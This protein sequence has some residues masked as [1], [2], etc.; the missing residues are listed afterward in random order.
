VTGFGE[1]ARQKILI[2]QVFDRSVKV[3][4]RC[5]FEK[6]KFYLRKVFGKRRGIKQI[7]KGIQDRETQKI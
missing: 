3:W 6:V 2:H 5:L 4:T 7:D 1:G